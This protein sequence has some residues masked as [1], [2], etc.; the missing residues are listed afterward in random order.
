MAEHLGGLVGIEVGDHDGLDLRVFVTDHVGH[1]T[2]L[3]PLQA[4]QAAGAAAE[5]DAVDQ[6]VGLVLAEGL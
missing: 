1:G 3:H 5:E 4:V 6:V 2:R